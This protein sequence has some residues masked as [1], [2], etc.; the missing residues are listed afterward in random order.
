[1]T[2]A[3][4]AFL[5]EPSLNPGLEDQAVNRIYRIGQNRPTTVVRFMTPTSIEDRILQMQERK[6]ALRDRR[7]EV[8]MRMEVGLQEADNANFLSN[9]EESILHE[10][11]LTA[12]SISE[13]DI[14]RGEMLI[15]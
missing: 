9:V 10:E 1:M 15:H 8:E 12:F 5:L 7:A 14:R 3:T 2:I 6:R 4:H 13:E 11:I